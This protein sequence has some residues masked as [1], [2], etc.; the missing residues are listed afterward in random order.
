MII[1]NKNTSDI[2]VDKVTELGLSSILQEELNDLEFINKRIAIYEELL[3]NLKKP[4]MSRKK[5]N[6]ER[7][8]FEGI[9]DKLYS[10]K[11]SITR[12]IAKSYEEILENN[13]S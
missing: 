12:D 2:L 11:D 5:Y 6:D 8:R 9:L 3:S 10:G 13:K 1:M 7:E 4:L